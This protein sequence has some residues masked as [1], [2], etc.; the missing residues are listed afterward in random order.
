ME[1]LLYSALVIC[2]I[3][4]ASCGGG[5]CDTSSITDAT[6][7]INDALSAYSSDPSQTNCDAY[8]AAIDDYISELDD[9]ELVPQETIDSFQTQR[10]ALTC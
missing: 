9:C 5:D 6:N 10:D 2:A 8:K 1:K 7:K 4:L 3:S